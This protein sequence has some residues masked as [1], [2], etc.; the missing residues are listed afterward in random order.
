MMIRKTDP[1]I[2]V[3]RHAAPLEY[4]LSSQVILILLQIFFNIVLL[5]KILNDGQYDFLKHS[6]LEFVSVGKIREGSP[7]FTCPIANRV[8]SM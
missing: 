6:Y 2:E 4:K 8:N 3:K 5:Y 1:T 7:F